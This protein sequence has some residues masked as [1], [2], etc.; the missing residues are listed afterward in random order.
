MG[1]FFCGVG[2]D[3]ENEFLDFDHRSNTTLL[4]NNVIRE[5][6]RVRSAIGKVFNRKIKVDFM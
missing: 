1:R 4:A 3:S 5:K 2:D 6:C